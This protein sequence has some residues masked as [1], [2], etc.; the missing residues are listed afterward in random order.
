[1]L[2]VGNQNFDLV[3]IVE[4]GAQRNHAAV[5]LGTDRLVAER[6]VDGVGEIDRG[7]TLGQLDQLALGREG[8]DP[9]LIHCHPGMLEQFL[10]AVGMVEDFDKILDPRYLDVV[11]RPALLVGPVGGETP[12]GLGVHHIVANLDLDPHLRIVDDRGMQRSIAIALG[13][14]DEVFEPPGHHRPAL[15][16]KAQRPVTI[17]DLVDDHPERHHVGQLLEADVALGHL[18]PDRE[19]VFFAPGDFGFKSMVGEVELQ[20]EADPADQIAAAG[21]ELVEPPPDRG[22]CVGLDLLE[23]QRLHLGH[24]V[25]HADPLRKRGIDIHRLPGDATALLLGGDVVE[26]AHVVQPVGQLDEQDANVA[27]QREQEFAEVFR[28]ALIFGLG[29]DLRQ[30]GHPVDQ[31]RDIG[32]EQFLDLFMGG[33]GILDRVVENC[34]DDRLVVELEIG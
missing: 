20:A 11:D 25:I 29:L 21:M 5:D 12:F 10:G 22:E 23:R 34:G 19:G 14:R 31:P 15:L 2:G 27:R 28:G 3:A 17:L 1:M 18:F 33:D 26:G 7:R 13:G 24:H 16:N 32:A 30:L 8:E 9:I 6:G 4:Q